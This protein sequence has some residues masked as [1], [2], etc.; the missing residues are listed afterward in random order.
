MPPKKRQSLSLVKSALADTSPAK[1]TGAASFDEWP[2]ASECGEEL[3]DAAGYC[4]IGAATHKEWFPNG[5]GPVS[6]KHHL[7]KLVGGKYLYI[8]PDA[9]LGTAANRFA[10]Y[11]PA[12]HGTLEAPKHKR[13]EAADSS[14]K[15]PRLGA[16]GRQRTVEFL[17]QTIDTLAQLRTD[18][19]KACN[20]DE[21]PVTKTYQDTLKKLENKMTSLDQ[22]HQTQ[23]EEDI[24]S[25]SMEEMQ[26]GVVILDVTTPFLFTAA[27]L[28]GGPN[29]RKSHT[30]S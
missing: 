3:P 12:I 21:L 16:P 26:R 14:A 23:A 13:A 7:R 9:D 8:V 29:L 24:I 15:R 20:V 2:G 25:A 18:A 1:S 4:V 5:S 30:E 10:R 27:Y 28:G 22:E 19:E 6:G 11:D 17:K